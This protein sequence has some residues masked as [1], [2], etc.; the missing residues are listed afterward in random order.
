MDGFYVRTDLVSA[1]GL[2][3]DLELG[4]EMNLKSRS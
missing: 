2:W 3:E 1:G 4:S